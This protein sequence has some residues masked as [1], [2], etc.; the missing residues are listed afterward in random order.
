MK[1]FI[2]DDA[3]DRHTLLRSFL[4]KEVVEAQISSA[5]NYDEG[6]RLVSSQ[7]FD[8]MFLDHDL[9]EVYYEH[10]AAR[11]NGTSFVRELTTLPMLRPKAIFIHSM[12]PDGANRMIDVLEYYNYTV[13]KFDITYGGYRFPNLENFHR[14][15]K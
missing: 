4:N 6:I 13:S 5:Y 11:K 10:Y 2:L 1:I 9:G 14:S 7:D 8:L 3:H 15:L 12:N